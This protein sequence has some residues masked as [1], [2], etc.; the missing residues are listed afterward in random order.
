LADPEPHIDTWT[1]SDGYV[2]HYRACL[3]RE[4]ARAILLC[5]H[6]IQSHG[7]WYE[8]SSA[9]LCQ[10][11]YAVY[12]LDRRG[13][14]LNQERRGDAPSFRRLL[15][16][17]YEFL[18]GLGHSV[19]ELPVVL[20]ACSWGGKLA[21]AFFR[22]YSGVADAMALLCPGICP[23][24]RPPFVQR[25][26]ILAS[27]LVRP[28]K[29]FPIP[30][31]DPALFTATPRWREFIAQD[32]LALREATARFLVESVRLDMYLRFVHRQV[33]VPAL[34]MLAEKDRIIDNR[35][36]R[37]Y[38]DR[39]A[40][41]DKQVIEYEGAHHTL[42]FEPDPDRFINDLVQW[43]RPREAKLLMSKRER[44]QARVRL[45]RV[46]QPAQLTPLVRTRSD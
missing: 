1:A 38:F 3:P 5:L 29:K 33:H 15:A 10:A 6:G 44:L 7:G 36:T 35:R 17:I 23:Q 20:V 37:A 34:L 45:A 24:V 18:V 41:Q 22:R 11:G 31:N 9:R 25:L 14:G 42:E 12:Y 43:L 19:C 28:R 21:P 40:S 30:L 46:P 8:Y 4:N 27:R 16:D 13:S 32:P 39:L 2:S 26:L